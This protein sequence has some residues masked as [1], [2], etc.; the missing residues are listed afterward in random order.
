MKKSILVIAAGILLFSACG[1]SAEE[2]AK[3]EQAIA[4]SISNVMAKKAEREKDSIARAIESQKREKDSIK[5]IEIIAKADAIYG[6]AVR[7]NSLSGL[8]E[9]KNIYESAEMYATSSYIKDMLNRKLRSLNSAI[10]NNPDMMREKLRAKEIK[11]PLEYLS[12][13]NLRI[14]TEV[15]ILEDNITRIKGKIH[16]SASVA[17]FK[18]VKCEMVFYSKTGSII[19]KEETTKYDFFEPNSTLNFSFKVKLPSSY[20]KYD[21]IIKSAIPCEEVGGD[22]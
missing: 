14:E 12:V 10:E 15:K 22:L 13:S 5:C 1:E 2:K 11:N 19:K 21:V 20:D 6:D 18:D 8:T 9:A 7:D 17:T 4:D 3:R 16:N